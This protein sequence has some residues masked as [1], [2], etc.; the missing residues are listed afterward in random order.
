M[1]IF[2]N[3]LNKKQEETVIEKKES[4]YIYAPMEGEVIPLQEIPDEVFSEGM[5]GKGCGMKPAEGKVYA[6]FD[7]E[8]VLVAN[9]KH[10]IALRSCDGIELLI[11]VGMD[12]VKMDGKGFNPHVK[13]GD[14]VKCGQLMM[15]FSIS[16]IE[17]AGYIT[18]T[19]I[20][21][22]NSEEYSNEAVLMQGVRKK[23]EKIM[24]VS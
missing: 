12:T 4:G 9:T 23:S 13:V 21:V 22:T 10:A 16:D 5:M 2:K 14:M 20:I 1:N 19:A 17:A 24:Q 7:G 18:T 15:T 6:P 8:V 3:F 11:H